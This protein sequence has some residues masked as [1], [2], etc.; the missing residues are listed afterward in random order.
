MISSGSVA[1]IGI[2]SGN[3]M[4]SHVS[5]GVRDLEDLQPVRRGIMGSLL[6]W[7]AFAFLAEDGQFA[8]EQCGITP[9]ELAAREASALACPTRRRRDQEGRRRDQHPHGMLLLSCGSANRKGGRGVQ[10][11]K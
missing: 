5:S 4:P 11:C 6:G 8:F 9:A 2:G 1:R 7:D 3:S 10:A